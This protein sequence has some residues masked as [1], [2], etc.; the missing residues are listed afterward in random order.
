MAQ[1]AIKRKAGQA[2]LSAVI[3]I[4]AKLP[5]APIKLHHIMM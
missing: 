2:R 4:A 3:F 5:G 1:N